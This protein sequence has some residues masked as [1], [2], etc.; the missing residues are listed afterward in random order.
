M[1]GFPTSLFPCLR[2]SQRAFFC[3]PRAFFLRPA[4]IFFFFLR[5]ACIFLWRPARCRASHNETPPT[6]HFW[7]K[8]LIKMAVSTCCR[9]SRN[10]TPPTVEMQSNSAASSAFYTNFE[11]TTEFFFKR[12]SPKDQSAI[13]LQEE[14]KTLF[15]SKVQFPDLWWCRRPHHRARTTNFHKRLI[16][17]NCNFSWFV[18]TNFSKL[19]TFSDQNM[20]EKAFS[21]NEF[22]K[23]C[24]ICEIYEN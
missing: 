21:K 3:S 6:M 14:T 15:S 2:G 23:I 4:C 5:L 12:L 24:P 16:F 20:Y 1:P 22:S 18:N 11:F 19:G 8:L 10:E 7:T 17:V 9:A 13:E